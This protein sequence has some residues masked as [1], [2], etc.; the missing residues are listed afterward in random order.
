MVNQHHWFTPLGGLEST[1]HIT[2]QKI[3]FQHEKAFHSNEYSDHDV[4][5]TLAVPK[6]TGT[7]TNN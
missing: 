6:G 7:R 2:G 4:C 3:N 1:F 5:I